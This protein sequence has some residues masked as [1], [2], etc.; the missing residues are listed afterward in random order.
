VFLVDGYNL[1]HAV[2]R[3]RATPEGRERLLAAIEEYCRKGGYAARVVFDATG[4]M[5][6]R[7]RRGPLEVRNVAEGRT[8]DEEI[9]EAIAGTADRT[10]YTVVSNDREIAAAAAKLGITVLPC[11][12][13][14]RRLEARPEAAEK[15]ESASDGEVDYWMREFGLEEGD[16]PR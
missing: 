8:A 2:A 9:L 14:A 4:G 16:A 7:D 10:R 15:A 12:E 11:E 1:L 13:F 3:G 5:K 6:R